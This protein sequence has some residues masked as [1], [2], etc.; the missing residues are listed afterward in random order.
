V[1]RTDADIVVVGGGVAGLAAAATVHD[2][3]ARVV[4]LEARDRIGG[5]ILTIRDD[6]LP[7]PIELGAEFIHGSA[8]ETVKLARDA[9][10][11][12][13]EVLGERWSA[14][15]GRVRRV[16][17]YWDRLDRVMRR[18]DPELDPDRSFKE[19][20]DSK[21]GGPSLARERTLAAEFVQGFHAADLRRISAKSLAD[22]GSPG[23]DPEEKRM[24]RVAGGYDAVPRVLARDIGD[25]IRLRSAATAVE[26][27]RGHVRVSVAGGTRRRRSTVSA[28]A[29]V[30]ALPLGVLQTPAP[31]D[32]ALAITPEI[33]SFREALGLVASGGV[34]RIVLG[35]RESFWTERLQRRAPKDATLACMHFLHALHAPIP[36]WWTPFPM[37]A[38]MLTG[39]VGGPRAWALMEKGPEYL[40]ST[41]IETLATHLGMTARSVA[42]LVTGFWMHDWL[43]DPYS[44]GAYSYPL[45][46]GSTAAKSLARPIQGTLF[47]AGEAIDSEMRSGT[48]HGAIGSGRRAAKAALRALG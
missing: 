30:V 3:G 2:A 12:T 44:R 48:V 40:L 24:A 39:W 20:L 4:L 5:R 47:F 27:S 36:V 10:L 7:I 16:D 8:P 15:A 46:G 41:A 37:R 21:P 32:G 6:R 42:G 31:A 34:V 9:G 29:A 35:F 23:D 25:A 38:P 17:D 45:V 1:K 33:P 19:F 26:W 18:L 13:Y 11:A 43:H 28:R 14:A 22:G